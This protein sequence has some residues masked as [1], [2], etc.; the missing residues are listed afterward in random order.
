MSAEHIAFS[1]RRVTIYAS[2]NDKAIG[3][4]ERFFVSPRGRMGTV[5]LDK[6]TAVDKAVMEKSGANLLSFSTTD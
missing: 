5:G 3:Y 1:A 6:I 4:A 2:P